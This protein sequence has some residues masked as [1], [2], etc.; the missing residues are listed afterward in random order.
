MGTA[1]PVKVWRWIIGGLL[2]GALAATDPFWELWPMLVQRVASRAG[3][4][5][6][7]WGEPAF[8]LAYLMVPGGLVGAGLGAVVGLIN[9]RRLPSPRPS[10]PRGEGGRPV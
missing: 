2:L 6:G 9:K 5:T 3:R 10:P 7:E 8:Y 1:Q 4:E